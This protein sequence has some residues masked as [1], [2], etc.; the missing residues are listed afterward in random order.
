[1]SR[2]REEAWDPN[3]RRLGALWDRA[4]PPAHA[5]A[6]EWGGDSPR[7]AASYS[8]RARRLP[9]ARPPTHAGAH[10]GHGGPRFRG[11]DR[12]G[13]RSRGARAAGGGDRGPGSSVMGGRRR[14]RRSR[15]RRE[16]A[17]LDAGVGAGVESTPR[18]LLSP[19]PPPVW[20]C[21]GAASRSAGGG[22]MSVCG[23]GPRPSNF[24][25]PAER[26]RRGRSAAPLL[27][28]PLRLWVGRSPRGDPRPGGEATT[29]AWAVR[30]PSAWCVWTGG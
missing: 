20:A 18:R 2:R 19:L 29:A 24:R 8:P 15:R 10:R 26:V 16:I 11:R 13:A 4:P 5:G 27:P 28:P 12:P 14:R 6:H 21:S 9:S 7:R 30:D 23:G 22:S 3:R 17:R 1:M 25:S